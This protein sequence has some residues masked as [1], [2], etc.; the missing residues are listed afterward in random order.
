MGFTVPTLEQTFDFARGLGRALLYGRDWTPNGKGGKWARWFAGVV[1]DLHAHIDAVKDDLMPDT[2]KGAARL[3][4]GKIKGVNPKGAT[5]AR[6]SN[7][8][9]VFGTPAATVSVGDELVSSGGLRFQVNENEVIPAAGNVAVDIVAIDTGSKTR[10][11]KGEVLTFTAPPAGIEEEAELILD[12]DEEGVDEE[13]EGD[14]R[15]RILER[16]FSPPLGGA[17]TDYVIWAKEVTG[18]ASAYAYPLRQGLNS[19]DLAALHGGSGT[20]RL[21]TAGEITALDTYVRARKPSGVTLRTLTVDDT[22][23]DVEVLVT[24]N[25]EA[26]YEFDWADSVPLVAHGAAPWDAGL[27]KLRFTTDRPASMKAGG[28]LTIK[29]IAGGGDGKQHVIESLSGTDAVILEAAPAIA[30]V[31]NDVIYSGGP[32]VDTLRDAIIAHIDSLGTSNTDAKAYLGW[33]ANLRP[34]NLSKIVQGVTGVK[35][36]TI[37]TPGATVEP[38]DNLYPNDGTVFILVARRILVRKG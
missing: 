2:A 14:H 18:I 25:G 23:V 28:R 11:P 10:L 16:F 19:V 13:S 4:W 7:A 26:S 32:L 37:S 35:K 34:E 38:A 21:L 17:Q 15:N 30:P 31:A 5:G 6:K 1:T 29:P 27:R 20:A 22:E 3:R 24:P 9:R 33:E 8:L 36:S 12:M